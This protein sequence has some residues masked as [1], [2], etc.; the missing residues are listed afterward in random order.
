MS[1]II[2]SHSNKDS[3][4]Q[5]SILISCTLIKYFLLAFFVCL[6]KFKW[7]HCISDFTQNDVQV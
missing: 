5:V 1:K 2:K 3:N 7:K 6:F 4:E